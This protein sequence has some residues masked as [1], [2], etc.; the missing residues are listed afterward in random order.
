MDMLKPKLLRQ[1]SA[2]PMPS[3]ILCA[4]ASVS[5][6]SGMD[7]DLNHLFKFIIDYQRLAWAGKQ[8]D[9]GL[10]IVRKEILTEG[11]DRSV[12]RF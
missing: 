1:F 9:I 7:M 5:A 8:F 10:Q 6:L 3:H 2:L 4:Y 12:V 11:I